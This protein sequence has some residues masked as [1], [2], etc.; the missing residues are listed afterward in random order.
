MATKKEM[1]APSIVLVSICLVAALL[2]AVTYQITAPLIEAINIKNAN[3]ARAEVLAA[4]GEE[5]FE[6]VE[7]DYVENV[8]EVYK[9]KNGSGYVITA[10]CKGF[11]G[12]IT[13]MTA[14]DTEGKIV[15]I[16]VT[17][18]SNETPG[19]GSKTTESSY[20]D[21]YIGGDA[22]ITNVP[23]TEGFY[24]ANI[25]GATY[26]SKGV[27]NAVSSAMQQFAQIGGAY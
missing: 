25:S 19:L 2:L 22:T 26:S 18:A 16:K 27:F 15:K 7:C 24:V 13:V 5:G 10:G 6:E 14:I 12:T 11:G 8:S 4:A 21:R 23:D 3:E 20:T 17:D 9:A 1:F